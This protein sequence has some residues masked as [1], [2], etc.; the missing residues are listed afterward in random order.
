[1]GAGNKSLMGTLVERTTRFMLS[2]KLDYKESDCTCLSNANKLN[3][4]PQIL[5]RS[6]TNDRRSELTEHEII[7]SLA[8]VK[9]YFC[10]LQSTWQCATNE[11]TN[12][13]IRQYILKRTDFNTVQEWVV[14]EVQDEFNDRLRK[15]FDFDNPET[16][17]L[18]TCCTTI[19][20]PPFFRIYLTEKNHLRVVPN[21]STT[22]ARV[23]TRSNL[24]W[25]F[26]SGA[27]FSI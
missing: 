2:V 10:D 7:E 14:R 17:I 6:L 20:R 16:E 27:N 9:I 3:E 24:W 21:P 22:R 1:M 4:F 25:T 18:R 8:E 13:L 5:C 12:G 15:V 19:L 26:P 23:S 11:N